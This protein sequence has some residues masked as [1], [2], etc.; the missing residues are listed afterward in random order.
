MAKSPNPKSTPKFPRTWEKSQAVGALKQRVQRNF[1]ILSTKIH[2]LSKFTQSE[3]KIVRRLAHCNHMTLNYPVLVS[4]EV[5][6]GPF[7]GN[8]V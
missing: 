7:F 2:L 8:T 6:R 5:S 1:T 4:P 3:L